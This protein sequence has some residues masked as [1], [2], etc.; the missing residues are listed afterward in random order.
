MDKVY[1]YGLCNFA[2]CTSTSPGEGFF[3]ERDAGVGG[4]FSLEWEWLDHTARFV[5]FF[6]WFDTITRYS[7]LYRRGWVVQ[8]RLISPRTMHFST[9]PFWECH[10]MV[11]C[12]A[13]PS[14]IYAQKFQWLSLPEKG[15]TRD[16]ESPEKTWL[17]IIE[18]YS[19]CDLT[20]ARDK[21]IALC[22]VA[23]MFSPSI[24]GHYLAG[25]WSTNLLQGLLWQVKKHVSGSDV[26]TERPLEYVGT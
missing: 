15:I 9:F 11:T 17:R 19:N 25:L 7:P 24:G 21:L 6:D 5:V 12:E 20:Y 3:R 1:E 13:Y 26:A 18:H 8:E 22:G 10:E 14:E 4:P 16:G 23:K 2:A